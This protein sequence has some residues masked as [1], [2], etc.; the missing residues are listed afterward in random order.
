MKHDLVLKNC[1][2]VNEGSILHA[3]I[4]IKGSR[5]EQISSSITGESK[6]EIELNGNLIIPGVIDD[7]VHFREP[8]L[9]HKGNIHTETLAALAGG[10]TSFF[11]MPNVNPPTT[12]LANLKEKF[13]LEGR[14]LRRVERMR[15][16]C[17]SACCPAWRRC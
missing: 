2:I 11:E 16:R 17:W 1:K 10:T 8:G 4:G 3:D 5:I 14:K 15:R 9:T 13:F 6:E 7:Q 12:T